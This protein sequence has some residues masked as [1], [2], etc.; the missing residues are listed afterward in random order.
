MQ[1]AVVRRTPRFESARTVVLVAGAMVLT[2]GLVKRA[3]LGSTLPLALVAVCLLLGTVRARPRL[4]LAL[5]LVL[6]CTVWLE[7]PVRLALGPLSTDLGQV[8]AGLLVLTLGLPA[9]ADVGRDVPYRVPLLLLVLALVS[10]ATTAL[11]RGTAQ[12]LVIGDLE[13][14]LLY[15]T[16]VPFCVCFRDARGKQALERWVLWLATAGSAVVLL[17]LAV[18]YPLQGRPGG[19][20][21]DV[22]DVISVGRLRPALL[23]LLFVATLLVA[24]Q[25]ALSGWSSSRV[26]RLALFTGVWAVSFNRSTW[27]C[28]VGSLALLVVLRPGP[29]RSRRLLANTLVGMLLLPVLVLGARGGHLGDTAEGVVRRA[30]SIGS[31]ATYS[32]ADPSFTDRAKEYR[33]GLS[34][35]SRSPVVGVGI[36]SSYG[37]RRY[38]YDAGLG[39]MRFFDRDYSHNS[40]LQLVLNLGLL[41][42]VAF[43][44]L[45]VAVVRE[46]VGT[47]AGSAAAAGTRS[48][49]AACALLGQGLEATVNP[50]LLGRGSVLALAVALALVARPREDRP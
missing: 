34:A 29:R 15:L 14:F 8:T 7:P 42:V 24:G 44:S 6:G 26:A 47:V 23:P 3:A 36:G 27:L 50:N 31:S 9:L 41:G 11:V 43:A 1:L 33:D 20:Y 30:T 21:V 5:V 4:C 45:G 38:V 18:G 35:L 12:A 46:V 48:V 37:A 49:A 22:H 16:V 17:A 2:F 19:G 39:R 25:V 10:G 28:L 32:S 13:A 40:W